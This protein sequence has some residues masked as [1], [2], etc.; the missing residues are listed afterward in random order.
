M[1]YYLSKITGY[2]LSPALWL[3]L[4]LLWPLVAR[5]PLVMKRRGIAAL[6]LAYLLMNP[7]LADEVLR[8]W[9]LPMNELEEQDKVYEA[10]VVLGGHMVSWDKAHQRYIFRD[11]TDRVLQAHALYARG[12]VKRIILSAGPGHPLRQQ[13]R[14][15]AYL[16][17]YLREVGVAAED[18]LIDTLSRNTR[19][20]AV[21]TSRI[22]KENGIEGEVL[23][24]TSASHMR[25]ARACFQETGIPFIPYVTDQLTGERRRDPEHLLVPSL[26]SLLK[27]RILTHEIVGM[28][29]YRLMGYA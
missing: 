19:E 24:V 3:L 8:R 21:E 22:L 14:E 9:E 29:A 13:E 20:N 26:D 28:L 17:A 12:Q 16:S 27:W 18:I 10:A 6:V 25:R 23:L 1:F 15:A 2:L 7:F 11:H 4:L 5:K